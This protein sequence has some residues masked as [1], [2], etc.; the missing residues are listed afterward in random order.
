MIYN[1]IRSKCDKTTYVP[2]GFLLGKYGSVKNIQNWVEKSREN[3][4][5]WFDFYLP[6]INPDIGTY[7]VL[8][9]F[10]RIRL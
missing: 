7:V 3:K 5:F 9:H 8:S 2:S 4:N 1:L 10:D 6:R